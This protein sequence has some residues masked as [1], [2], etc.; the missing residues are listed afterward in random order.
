[1]IDIKSQHNLKYGQKNKCQ[2]CGNIKLKPIINLGL[3]PPCDSLIQLKKK[4]FFNELYFPLN[5]VWCSKCI[6]GQ[7]DY[8]VDPKLLFYPEYP[9]RSGIT[10]TLAKNLISL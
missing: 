1:M 2:I 8:V 5:F 4:D 10:S 3:Q 9:Y 7:I 6:L